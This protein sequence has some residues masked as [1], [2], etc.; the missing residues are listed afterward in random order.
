MYRLSLEY[1]SHHLRLLVCHV[2]ELHIQ[3]VPNEPCSICVDHSCMHSPILLLSVNLACR[4]SWSYK[5][6]RTNSSM[7]HRISMKWSLN[8]WIAYSTLFCQCM[9]DGI[10][11]YVIPLFLIASLY[12]LDASLLSIWCFGFIP[13]HTIIWSMTNIPFSFHLPCNFSLLLPKWHFH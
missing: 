1:G 6:M 4:R 12:S 10:N 3:V 8:V 5:C 7:P 13:L 9:P 11:S 2:L